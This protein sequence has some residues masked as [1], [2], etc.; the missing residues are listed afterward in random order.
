MSYSHDIRKALS[1]IV[2]HLKLLV[3]FV[4]HLCSLDRPNTHSMWE[5]STVSIQLIHNL[6]SAQLQ[7]IQGITPCKAK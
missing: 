2:F 4:N 7:T 5:Y 1:I 3:F 6:N